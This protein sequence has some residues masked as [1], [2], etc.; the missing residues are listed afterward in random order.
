MPEL[1]VR[2]GLVGFKPTILLKHFDNHPAINV[3]INTHYG[4]DCQTQFYIERIKMR[5]GDLLPEPH[6][7]ALFGCNR[8]QRY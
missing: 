6:K 3:C 1:D 2:P 4:A 7:G 5:P 8:D